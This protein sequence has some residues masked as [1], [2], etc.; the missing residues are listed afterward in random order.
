MAGPEPQAAAAPAPATGVQALEREALA[1]AP[2]LFR[3]AARLTGSAADADDVLQ[4]AFTRAITA[5][6][7]GAF[8]GDSSLS[9]WLY[10]ITTNV[11]LDRVRQA[12]GQQTEQASG[13]EEPAAPGGPEATVALGELAAAMAELPDDQRAALVLKEE[14]GLPTREVAQ[15]L[16][17]S[18]GATEQLLVRARAALRRRLEP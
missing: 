3:L 13:E 10:R 15:V 4:D 6:R 5:L 12:K 8:K 18:E 16:E 2:Q 14:Q 11:A 7:R 9:T 17:R 1:L